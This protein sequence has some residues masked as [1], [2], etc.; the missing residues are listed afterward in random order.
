MP[1]T[2]TNRLIG[3][4]GSLEPAVDD[5]ALE[6]QRSFDFYERH[7]AQVSIGS[8]VVTPQEFDMDPLVNSLHASLGIDVTALD[9]GQLVEHPDP[10][11]THAGRCLLAIGAALREDEVGT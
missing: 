8:L 9:I 5:I 7:F 6:I 1:A 3:E 2:G 4:N 10:L 11:P